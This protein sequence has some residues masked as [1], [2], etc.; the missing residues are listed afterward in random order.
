MEC[1]PNRNVATSGPF[2]LHNALLRALRDSLVGIDIGNTCRHTG[3]RDGAKAREDRL[4]LVAQ[5]EAER[6]GGEER[7]GLAA[8]RE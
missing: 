1:I 4:L 7:R 6:P 8:H 3:H 5:P 2:K